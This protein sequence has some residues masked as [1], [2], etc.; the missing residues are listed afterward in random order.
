MRDL[1]SDIFEKTQVKHPLQD[2]LRVLLHLDD[3]LHDDILDVIGI[4]D[5]LAA[6]DVATYRHSLNVAYQALLIGMPCE[7]NDVML[8]KL[9]LA[10]LL[11]DIGKLSIPIEILN[12]T[13]R[14]TEAEYTMMKSHCDCGFC[15]LVLQGENSHR[16]DEVIELAHV[17]RCHHENY[18]GSGYGSGLSGQDI[19]F[20][21]RIIR[22]ADAFDA[23]LMERSYKGSIPLRTVQELML[24]DNGHF[25]DPKL[26]RLLFLAD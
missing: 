14:L 15:Y 16:M 21:S 5:K 2:D 10:A 6:F 12:K 22:I 24:S 23:M 13:G 19:P 7:L 25:Y 17:V 26:V 11:H 20:L 9:A 4:L 3:V 18:D 8:H 1:F